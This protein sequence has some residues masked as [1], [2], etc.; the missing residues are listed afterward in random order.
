MVVVVADGTTGTVG[1][2]DGV[3]LRDLVWPL[4]PPLVLLLVVLLLLLL[5]LLLRLLLLLPPLLSR[6]R[7]NKLH[8][9]LDVDLFSGDAWS[10]SPSVAAVAL[11]SS[12]ASSARTRAA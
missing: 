12:S 7:W 3:W 11:L 8:R 9:L 5:L 2:G 10:P 4:P 1:G 6:R